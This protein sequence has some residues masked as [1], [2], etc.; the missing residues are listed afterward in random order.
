MRQSTSDFG[1]L[2]EETLE[3]ARQRVLPTLRAHVHGLPPPQHRWAAFHFGWGDAEGNPLTG[4]LPGKGL[5][6]ALVYAAA[7]AAG[8]PSGRLDQVAAAVELVHNFCIV[9]DDVLDQDRQRRGRP[10]VWTQFG[11]SA[12]LLCGDSLLALALACLDDKRLVG[13][14]C[15]AVQELIR[16]EALDIEYESRRDL[17]TDDY[18]LMAELKTGSLMGA[19]CA[20]GAAGAGGAPELVFRMGRF[21]RNL[22]LAFQIADDLLGVFG[23]PA[24][25]GKPV[26]A[27]LRRRKWTYPVLAALSCPGPAARPLRD[28]YRG[29]G[30]PSDEQVAECTRAIEQAGAGDVSRAVALKAL[31]DAEECLRDCGLDP[32]Q[33]APLRAIAAMVVDRAW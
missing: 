25:I 32:R 27:D 9:H 26:G 21:G 15:K 2:A 10:T 31:A 13:P 23:D 5:R 24:V 29:S 1:S 7:Q 28:L 17:T 8:R 4:G 12:A 18:L 6:P 11:P 3:H 30:P 14:L 20:L 22:G 33:T 19:A 16:G